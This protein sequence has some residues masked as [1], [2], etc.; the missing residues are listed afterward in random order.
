MNASQTPV[1]ANSGVQGPNLADMRINYGAGKLHRTDLRADPFEQF[2]LWFQE[3]CQSGLLEPN[4]MTVA[5]VGA[6]GRPSVRTVLLKHWD[7]RGFV[8]FTNLESRKAEQI[9]TH[10]QVALLFTWLPLQRQLAINGVAERVT[11]AEVLAYFVKRPYG[12]QLAAWVSP[13]SK[14]ISKRALLEMK[15]EEM[16][17]KFR[18]GEVPL[19]SFWGGFRVVPQEIEFW[20]GRE[21]RLHDRFL[22]QRSPEGSWTVDRLAP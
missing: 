15:W 16:K 7:P 6:D 17:R 18:E 19:P 22:Y 9:G 21:S 4:A 5:T 12:S 2:G 20:Q 3:A 14:I 11:T 1:P 13:Q 10:P 8:F